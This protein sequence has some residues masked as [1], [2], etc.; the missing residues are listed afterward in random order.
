MDTREAATRSTLSR[1]RF[2]GALSASLTATLVGCGGPGSAPAGPSRSDEARASATATAKPGQPFTMFVY[3]GLTERAYRELFVPGFEKE[4]G[5][6]VTLD[7]GWWDMAAKLKVA[8]ADQAP[9]DL[10]M[11]DPTQGFPGI[12]DNLF[13]KVSLERI[14]NARRFAPKVLD[15][16]IY[17][18]GWGV[19]FVSSAMTL[20]W[21]K[22]LVPGGLKSWGDLFAEGLKGEIMLYNA[23]YMSLYTFA[24]AKA[25]L[26]GKPGTARQ[27]IETDLDSVLAFAREKRE[28]VKYWWPATSDAVLALLQ[29]NVKAGNIHGNGLI[30]PLKDGKPLGLAIPK[31]D[32]AYVQLF[33][34]VPKNTRDVRLAERAIDLIAGPEFQRAIAEKTGELSCNIP[35]IAAEIA[36]NSPIWARVYPNT[37]ADWD[38]LAY[39]PFDAYDRQAQKIVS[40]WN[41]EVLRKG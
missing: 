41:R 14:P 40:F 23:W 8:P 29:R 1:R 27:S 25:A 19:P 26:D 2:L 28:W 18:D 24:A 34:L 39:Y 33:F 31:E 5:A 35:E 12:R 10:V 16:W 6:N 13:T 22:E 17:R 36:P 15:S 21:H 3:S 20:A 38:D 9:F 11:T 30:Q 37:A 7:P 32:R 4:T